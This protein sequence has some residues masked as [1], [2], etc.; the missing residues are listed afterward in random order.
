M[1]LTTCMWKRV[2]PQSDTV[3]LLYQKIYQIKKKA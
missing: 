3:H 1:L 2:Y